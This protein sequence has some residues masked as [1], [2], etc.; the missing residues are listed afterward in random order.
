MADRLATL[1]LSLL[2]CVN[3]ELFVSISRPSQVSNLHSA[4]GSPIM[5]HNNLICYLLAALAVSLSVGI[6]MDSTDLC[7][8]SILCVV[9]LWS[10]VA[11][12]VS[13]ALVVH[14]ARL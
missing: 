7:T 13:L 9:R 2:F 3:L 14:V 12:W 8:A 10:R 5:S 11:R 6:S 1:L 4:T